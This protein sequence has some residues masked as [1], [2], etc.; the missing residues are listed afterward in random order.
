MVGMASMTSTRAVG[1]PIPP[2]ENG[3]RLTREEFERRFDATP[4]LKRAELIEGVVYM[5]PPVSYDHGNT[6]FELITWA[7]VYS[8]STPGVRGGGNSTIRMDLDNEPQPDVFLMIEPSSGGQAKISED[9]YVEGAPELV[10]E[11]AATSASYDLHNK[12]EVYRKQGVREYLV[13]RVYDEQLDW[14]VWTKSRFV[15]IAP[16]QSGIIRSK[17]FPGLWLDVNAVVRGDIAAVLRVLQEGLATREHAEF[18][19]KLQAAGQSK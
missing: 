1:K 9:R 17:V 13:L 8:A 19:K 10:A 14:F 12:M 18:V 2:L 7:G 11:V 6:N 4:N 5:T 16:D 15:R 3:D